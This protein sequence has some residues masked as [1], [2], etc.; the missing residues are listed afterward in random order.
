MEEKP[1]CPEAAARRTKKLMI[2]GSPVGLARLDEVMDEVKKLG[3]LG[4]SEIGDELL[5]KI[6]IFNYV[7]SSASL[8][9]IRALLEE[10]HRRVDS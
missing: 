2:S 7:P 4:D 10:Y 9:Y 3:L 5:K 6:K 8:E 1:C